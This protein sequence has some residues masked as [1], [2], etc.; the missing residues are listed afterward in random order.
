MKQYNFQK[1]ICTITG[2]DDIFILNINLYRGVPCKTIDLSIQK[3]TVF[4]SSITSEKNTVPRLS[5]NSFCD[6]IKNDTVNWSWG[7][8][9]KWDFFDLRVIADKYTSNNRIPGTRAQI[10][11]LNFYSLG[12]YK[13][14]PEQV[15]LLKQKEMYI[16]NDWEYGSGWLTEEIPEDVVNRIITLCQRNK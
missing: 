5:L 7:R 12:S 16:D 6:L 9:D 8:R 3:S 15:K 14:F 11:L 2:I 10:D 1:P 4:S 13:D